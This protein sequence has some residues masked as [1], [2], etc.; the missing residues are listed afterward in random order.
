ME[1][2][3]GLSQ[4][5][6]VA[7]VAVALFLA[8]FLDDIIILFTMVHGGKG[9]AFPILVVIILLYILFFLALPALFN[10]GV[11]GVMFF[12][13]LKEE[14]PKSMKLFGVITVFQLSLFIIF[15]LVSI[16]LIGLLTGH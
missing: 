1:R 10:A 4:R 11:G 2:K 9:G 13:S 3:K 6:L 16:F 15:S 12:R 5:V 8:L 7:L 14:N